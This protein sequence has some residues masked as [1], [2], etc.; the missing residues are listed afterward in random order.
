MEDELV[1]YPYKVTV[2]ICKM[3]LLTG[4]RTDICP[5]RNVNVC[6]TCGTRKPTR[7]PAY[8]PKCVI[9]DAYSPTG[10]SLCKKKLKNV[11]AP[12]KTRKELP[13][14][15][16]GQSEWTRDASSDTEFPQL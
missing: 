16:G 1:C 6:P 8:T 13:R 15:K 12:R 4:H 14:K 9:C 11:A 3:C 7:T 10:D 5:T 2:Q